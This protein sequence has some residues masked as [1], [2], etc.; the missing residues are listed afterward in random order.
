YSV[1]LCNFLD[2]RTPS[3]TSLE[4]HTNVELATAKAEL[5]KLRNLTEEK[6]ELIA[7]LRDELEI[8][9]ADL[10]KMQQER[11][12]LIKDARAAKDYRDELDCLQHKV[13]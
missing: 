11:L 1:H 12:E 3:P 5:R 7:E 6:D 9:E 13:N 4:R 10:L 2:G 8:R